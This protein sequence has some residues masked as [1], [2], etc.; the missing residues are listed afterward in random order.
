MSPSASDSHKHVSVAN[1]AHV[2]GT[3]SQEPL[4]NQ[5][6]NG[7]LEYERP[8]HAV[9]EGALPG[10]E[11]TVSH[12]ACE[13]GAPRR[14]RLLWHAWIAHYTAATCNRDAPNVIR[15]HVIA[16]SV[17]FDKCLSRCKSFRRMAQVTTKDQFAQFVEG[18]VIEGKMDASNDADSFAKDTER[19]GM[20]VPDVRQRA[21]GSPDVLAER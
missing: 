2:R 18:C 19:L 20:K 10:G 17:S 4:H 12:G 8:A 9:L 6:V 7:Q 11:L 5:L 15:S 3:E 14:T 16:F 21:L 13:A 1:D